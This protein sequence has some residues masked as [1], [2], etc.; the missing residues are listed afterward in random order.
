MEKKPLYHFFPGSR[1]LSF[2]TIGCNLGCK[3]CQ[4]WHQSKARHLGKNSDF[5]APHSVVKLAQQQHCPSIAFTYNDPVIFAEYAIDVAKAAHEHGLQTAAVTAGYINPAAR[6][7]FFAHM[8]AANV[9]LK[10]MSEVFYRRLCGVSLAP[11]LQTLEYLAQT[12][13]WVEISN[14]VI[15]GANDSD[16]DF[17][18]LASWVVEHMG[19]DVPIH[20]S[21]YH[22]DYRFTNIPRTPLQTLS[23]ARDLAM[24]AGARFVYIGNAY[25]A[26]GQQTRCPSC[27]S[28]VIERKNYTLHALNLDVLGRCSRCSTHIAGRFNADPT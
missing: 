27:D 21:A 23:R 16:A 6:E 17:A 2:G 5:V 12:K 15:P 25:D 28:Y 22:P 7:L 19:P 4:N 13:V 1:V 24:Q 11:V 10:S 8:D 20:F 26:E 9:D 18:A 3:F 14:L